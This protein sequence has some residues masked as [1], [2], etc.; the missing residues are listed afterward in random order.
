MMAILSSRVIINVRK[1]V[2]TTTYD[3]ATISADPL[4]FAVNP[5]GTQSSG[6]WR[7]ESHATGAGASVTTV[8]RSVRRHVDTDAIEMN[9]KDISKIVLPGAYAT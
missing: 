1:A 3:L 9:C 7:P 4:H 8:H 5:N 2:G 6:D